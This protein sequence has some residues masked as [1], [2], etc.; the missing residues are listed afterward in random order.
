MPTLKVKVEVVGIVECH[1]LLVSSFV[2]KNEA[3][4]LREHED[5]QPLTNFD[6][7]P[8]RGVLREG[9]VKVSGEWHGRSQNFNGWGRSF[10]Q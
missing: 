10:S 2:G 7:S 3:E 1:H 8:H 6:A 4:L 9:E 5:G